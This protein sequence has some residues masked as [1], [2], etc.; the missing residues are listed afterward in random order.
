[1]PKKTP[2]KETAADQAVTRAA[3]ENSGGTLLAHVEGIEEVLARVADLKEQLSVKY[4]GVATDGYDKKAV[5]ALVRRRAMTADQ[6]KVQ[7]ELS[8]VVAVYESALLSLEIRGLVYGE[9]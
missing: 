6:V 9:D 3:L 1:M 8:L 4:A 5:K 7:G 2:M